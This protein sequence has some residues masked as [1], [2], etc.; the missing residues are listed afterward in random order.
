MKRLL[1]PLAVAAI[2]LLGGCGGGEG[3]A[4]V[5][6]PSTTAPATTALAPVEATPSH[7]TL[8]ARPDVDVE[9]FAN[10]ADDAAVVT[11]LPAK[12]EFGSA[13]ALPVLAQRD[14]WL[15]VS[16]PIRP[17]GSTGWIRAGGVELRR[18]D[19]KITVDL[20]ARTLTL[21]IDGAAVLTT[22]IAI[23]TPDAPTPTGTFF[24]ADKLATNNESSA[25]GPF[26]FGLSGHSE[27][28]TEF[29]G[30]DG[31][32]GIHGTNDPSS[33]GRNVSHGCVRVPN[34]VIVQLNDHVPLGTPVTIV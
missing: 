20:A 21:S 34:D 12:T 15:E 10:P 5:A 22:E 3:A 32:V 8:V 30:G 19:E 28:L 9:V 7:E 6:A 25:Y 29:A 18:V 1:A 2:A 14:G 33:I 16:L 27:V 11:V 4:P 17:N 23:G 13:R 24:V 31:Q 26:A